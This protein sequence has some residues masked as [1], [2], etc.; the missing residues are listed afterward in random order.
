M[1]CPNET[2]ERR[3]ITEEWV[4][5]DV[6]A[7]VVAEIGHRRWIE[8][9]DPDS[10]DIERVRTALEMVESL[11]NPFKISDTI[12]IRILERADVDL[13]NH[14][15]VPPSPVHVYSFASRRYFAR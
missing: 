15:A 12:A 10:I 13:V 5:I 7:D 8:W 2:V 11:P 3:Q 4:D 14:A 9:R 6:V 1:A